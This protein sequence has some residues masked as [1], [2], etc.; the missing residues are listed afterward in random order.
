M[1]ENLVPQDPLQSHCAG[2][3]LIPFLTSF[4]LYLEQH[5]EFCS[6]GEESPQHCPQRQEEHLKENQTGDIARLAGD[7]GLA[8]LKPE[9]SC[10]RMPPKFETNKPGMEQSCR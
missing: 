8:L 10:T 9:E 2:R 6:K 7:I 5:L 4:F 3:M 1:D